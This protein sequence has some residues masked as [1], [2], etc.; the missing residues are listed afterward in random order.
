MDISPHGYWIGYDPKEHRFDADLADSIIE[1][2]Q[3]N[4]Y[5]TIM[6]VGCGRGQYVQHF[7]NHNTIL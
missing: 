2:M 7:T 4:K 3:I 5:R 6:D 1:I